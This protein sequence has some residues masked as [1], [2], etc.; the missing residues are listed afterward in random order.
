MITYVLTPSG[1]LLGTYAM[2]GS[3]PLSIQMKRLE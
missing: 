2:E 1:E 3:R